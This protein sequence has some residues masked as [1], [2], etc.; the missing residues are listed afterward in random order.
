MAGEAAVCPAPC[1]NAIIRSRPCS[2]TS[3]FPS[4]P[5]PIQPPPE[6]Q[7]A[8]LGNLSHSPTTG[9]VWLCIQV[10][11]PDHDCSDVTF[12]TPSCPTPSQFFL[13]TF[14]SLGGQSLHSRTPALP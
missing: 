8:A 9:S 1:Q 6:F 2:L 5:R 4:A 3:R 10:P 11:D 14:H 13:A 12:P 7:I